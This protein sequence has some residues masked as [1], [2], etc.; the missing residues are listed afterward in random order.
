VWKL[1][2]RLLLLDF[3]KRSLRNAILEGMDSTSTVARTTT[4]NDDS[5][6]L[7]NVLRAC[8]H[9]TERGGPLFPLR[10][11]NSSSRGTRGPAFGRIQNQSQPEKGIR[12]IDDLIVLE[13]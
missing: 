5:A 4:L 3:E 12:K 8:A 1:T 10:M 9:R 11:R 2:Q 7:R 13:G 6:L